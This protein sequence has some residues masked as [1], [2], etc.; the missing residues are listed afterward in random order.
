[1]VLEFLQ[2]ALDVSSLVDQQGNTLL[3]NAAYGGRMDLVKFL[4]NSHVPLNPKNQFGLTPLDL[5]YAGHFCN[6]AELLVTH[7][8]KRTRSSG[9]CNREDF[10]TDLPKSLVPI[11]DAILE[12]DS[13][14]YLL[15]Q[16]YVDSGWIS[17]QGAA[18]GNHDC[19]IDVRN[20]S[21]SH[22]RTSCLGT[23]VHIGL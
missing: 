23:R 4:L 20:S 8:A 16:R 17:P 7:G 21:L 22:R 3:H 5:S 13:S 15:W 2:P 10:V 1:M 18:A 14:Q 9:E 6:V 19:G 11:I 12:H